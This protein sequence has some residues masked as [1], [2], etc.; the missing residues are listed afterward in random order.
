MSKFQQ[1]LIVIALFVS[2]F[3]YS[4]NNTPLLDRK[5]NVN[6]TNTPLKEALF[7]LSKKGSFN[8]SYNSTILTSNYSVSFNCN[9]KKFPQ[10][11]MKFY[12]II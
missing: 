9:K 11:W 2:T 3:V 6:F 12:P 8:L 5:L 7:E 4:Q 1:T 10:Y